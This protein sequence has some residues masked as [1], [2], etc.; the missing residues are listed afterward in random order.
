MRAV[1]LLNYRSRGG[2]RPPLGRI[3]NAFQQ[4]GWDAEVWAGDGPEWTL[5]AARRAVD[6]GVD[7]V[8][9]AGGD[10]VLATILPALRGTD[11]ALGVVPLGTGNVWARELGLPLDPAAAIAAQL[12]APS[13]RV[14]IGLLNRK[15][16]LVVASA[17]LDA[18]IVEVVEAGMKGL[19][20]AAYP[21]AGLGLL[22]EVRGARCRVRLDAEEIEVPLLA[23]VVTN[24]RLYGGLVSL[25]PNARVDD[26]QL[27]VVLFE[28]TDPFQ[29]AA[30]VARVLAGQHHRDANIHI[31]SA[32]SVRIESLD[33]PLPVQADGDP[34]G[35]TPVRITLEPRA[36]LAL[37]VPKHGS[38]GTPELG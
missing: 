3:L 37:G 6:T 7:A 26:G 21:L 9:G 1:V 31:S 14:D 25:V 35:T 22:G 33:R 24:G 8:F 19:G 5:D 38:S 10:G 34:R 16:F 17:G 13:R 23:A 2:G 28:G 4:G 36:V 27:D 18:K 30:H 11:T 29:L 15:P 12:K 20:Q 32:Q